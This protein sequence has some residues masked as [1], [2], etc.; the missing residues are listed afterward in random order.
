VDY[1]D[2]LELLS[3]RARARW[4]FTTA[5]NRADRG[6][7]KTALRLIK[8]M[9][10]MAEVIAGVTRSCLFRNPDA[11][12]RRKEREKE[13]ERERVCADGR[14]REISAAP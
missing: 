4:R 11:V 3:L 8:G 12:S 10:R 1:V 7:D 13:R 2:R 5:V 9:A 14:A 6:D